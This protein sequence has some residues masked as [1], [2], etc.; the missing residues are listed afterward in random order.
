MVYFVG[1]GPGSLDYLTLRGHALL[2]Q[3]DVVFYDALV[4]PELLTV[5]PATCE[6]LSVGKRSQ[7]PSIAQAQINQ[8]LVDRCRRGQ[9]VVRLKGGDAG[10]F[11]RLRDELVALNQAGC[12]YEVIPGV[13]AALAAPLLAGL[14][15]TDKHQSRV[16]AICT[17]HDLETLDWPTLA[18]LDTLILLM[19]TQNLGAILRRLRTLGRPDHEAIA[20]IRWAGHPQQQAWFGTLAT[21]QDQLA[22]WDLAPAVMVI[23][24]AAEPPF[25]VR[26]ENVPPSPSP[27]S[28]A[29]SISHPLRGQTILVTRAASQASAFTQQLQRAGAT[30]LEMP[31]LEIGPPQDWQAMDQ[32]LQHLDT[33]DWLILTSHNGVHFF[34]QRLQELGLD[35]RALGTLKIAVVGEKT[36]QTLSHHGLRPDFVP[37]AFIADALIAHFPVPVAGLSILFPRV[38]TGGRPVLGEAFRAAGAQVMEVAAYESRC[39]TQVDSAIL[40]A[41]EQQ[42][43][44]LV[45][46]TSSKTVRHFC[47][48]L[49]GGDRTQEL[50]NQVKIASIGPQTS[51]TCQ[52]LL[53][54]VDIEAQEHSLEG[55]FAALCQG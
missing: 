30:V 24:A 6:C 15:L 42:Q 38:E 50:L 16:L 47:Q 18:R 35:S 17:A 8:Y 39:P 41:L 36:A 11:G 45:T 48:L 4:A 51:Q 32:A 3:A 49:G 37:P 33:F 25:A 9:R 46:F 27:D 53:G 54:R 19:A 28:M 31:T 40:R 21:I 5:C 7:G 44:H 13:S 12:A 2:Q 43:I 22:G 52:T 10:I 34:F 55:L 1:A 20:L 23:G 26:L 29:V 14:C